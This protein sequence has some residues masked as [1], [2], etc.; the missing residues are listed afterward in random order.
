MIIPTK[1]TT[2]NEFVS[3]MIIDFPMEN[4][5]SETNENNWKIWGSNLAQLSIFEKNGT[6]DPNGFENRTD[7]EQAVFN[8]MASF[9]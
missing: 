2:F 4:I 7:W 6:P 5:P 3:S 8:S 9:S 1:D